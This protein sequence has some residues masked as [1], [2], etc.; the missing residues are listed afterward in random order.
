MLPQQQLSHHSV[1]WPLQWQMPLLILVVTHLC[2]FFDNGSQQTLIAKEFVQKTG[3]T[4]KST[5]K[6]TLKGYKSPMIVQEYPI[7]KPVI[8]MGNRRKRVNAVVVD[9]LPDVI[10]VAGLTEVTKKLVN[11]ALTLHG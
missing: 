7:V 8:K 3:M 2:I 11:M 6:M 10:T 9:E 4:I 1:E 5:A